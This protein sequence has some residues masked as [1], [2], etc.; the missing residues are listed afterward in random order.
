MAHFSLAVFLEFY[1]SC[2]WDLRADLL[3]RF[4]T[5]ETRL[6]V[7]ALNADHMV[8]YYAIHGL[9]IRLGVPVS[10]SPRGLC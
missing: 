2:V 4:A 6:G 9:Y 10:P 3:L 1:C 8:R 5:Y 7:E